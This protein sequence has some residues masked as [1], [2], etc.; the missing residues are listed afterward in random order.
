[1]TTPTY[2]II[3]ATTPSH[4][5]TARTLFTTYAQYL[6]IDLTFQNFE[7]ELSSLPGKY[8]PPDGEILLAYSNT[9]P[10]MPLGCV[11]LR[12]LPSPPES[13]RQYCEVK[14]L[15]VAPEARGLGLGRALVNAIVERARELGYREMRLDTL[16][17]MEGP[18]RLYQS[19]GF[20]EI[21][22][23]YDATAA[24]LYKEMVFLGR[25]IWVQG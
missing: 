3:P 21:E 16:R 19:L 7:A 11:A 18:V 2:H 23:Y 8:S 4:L 9:S 14:R 20:V 12:P 6:N 5:T 22:P 13:P 10:P 17:T 15:Y 24:P 25:E 1:M